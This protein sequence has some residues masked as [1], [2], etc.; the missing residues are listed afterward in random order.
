MNQHV[1]KTALKAGTLSARPMLMRGRQSGPG[2]E[3]RGPFRVSVPTTSSGRR[4]L[5]IDG[6]SGATLVGAFFFCGTFTAFTSSL[7]MR[8]TDQKAKSGMFRFVI[9]IFV[10]GML[11]AGAYLT[12]WTP[13]Q[14]EQAPPHAIDQT[15]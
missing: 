1:F 9:A 4:P 14:T 7:G 10:I 15:N 11:L 8:D 12:F 6:R 13:G 5:R 3:L 2:E